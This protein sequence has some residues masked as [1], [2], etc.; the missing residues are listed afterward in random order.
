MTN[1]HTDIMTNSKQ[2]KDPNALKIASFRTKEGVW[3]EFCQKAE[4]IGLTATDVIKASM[5]QFISGDYNPRSIHTTVSTNVVHHDSVLTCHDVLGIVNTAVN[6][7]SLLNHDDVMTRINDAI[8]NRVLPLI[9]SATARVVA[10]ELL[11][12]STDATVLEELVKVNIEAHDRRVAE[13]ETY[14]QSQFAAMRDEL[15]AIS[16]RSVTTEAVAQAHPKVVATVPDLVLP[17]D[18]RVEYLSFHQLATQLGYVLPVELKDKPP[19]VRA[20][21]LMAYAATLGQSYGW[22]GK[23]QK[24]YRTEV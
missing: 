13:L 4:S 24:F 20:T 2:A 21:A 8:D 14:T 6:T 16:N 23:K 19:Q 1:E 18:D 3:A 5:E 9:E 11:K 7:L 22:N 12:T 15:R 17:T 10:S